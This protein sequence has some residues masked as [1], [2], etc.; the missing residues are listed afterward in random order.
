MHIIVYVYI[1]STCSCQ[2]HI[3][4][5]YF[6]LPVNRSCLL[7]TLPI[8]PFHTSSMGRNVISKL[9]LQ[10]DKFFSDGFEREKTRD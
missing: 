8:S 4:I 2:I 7:S 5:A 3:H 9:F 6:G 1:L 10:R